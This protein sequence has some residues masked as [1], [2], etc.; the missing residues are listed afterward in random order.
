MVNHA[1]GPITRA[2]NYA[3]LREGLS[4]TQSRRLRRLVEGAKRPRAVQLAL[5]RRIMAE[6]ADTEFGKNH[7][8]SKVVDSA[9]Y[10]QSTLGADIR[11]PASSDRTPGTDG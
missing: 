10:R 6:N 9:I 8:F 3:L 2:A 11:R 5:L 7:G 4:L 1:L